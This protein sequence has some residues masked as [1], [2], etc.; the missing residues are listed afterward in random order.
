MYHSDPMAA[1]GMSIAQNV[2]KNTQEYTQTY[3]DTQ[4]DTDTDTDRDTH[5][6]THTMIHK[7]SYI[8]AVSQRQN[9]IVVNLIFF[10]HTSNISYEIMTDIYWLQ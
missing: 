3:T 4:T 7:F 1:F 2:C 9:K 10:H 5:R 8:R 6:H